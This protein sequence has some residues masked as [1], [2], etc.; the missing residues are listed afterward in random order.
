MAQEHPARLVH[1]LVPAEEDDGELSQLLESLGATFR[2]RGARGSPTAGNT[3]L[4]AHCS[5]TRE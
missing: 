3:T 5:P 1:Q 4:T 2:A